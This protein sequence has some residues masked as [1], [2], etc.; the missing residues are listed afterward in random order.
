MR[1]RLVGSQQEI[2]QAAGGLGANPGQTA[3]GIDQLTDWFCEWLH[4][5]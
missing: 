1:D 5:M 3:K 4:M 2:G